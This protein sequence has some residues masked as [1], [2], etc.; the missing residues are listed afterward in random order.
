MAKT[1]YF[2][3]W[4]EA[5]PTRNATYQV[6]M[7]FLEENIL[8]RF[9]FPRKII[10]GNAQVFK[11][12]ELIN[13]CHKYNIILGH[14]T[15]YPQGNGQVESSNKGLV[16][17]IKNMLFENKKGWDSKLKYALW[18]DI[19]ITKNQLELPLFSLFMERK[20]YFLFI[21]GYLL[22]NFCKKNWKSLILFKGGFVS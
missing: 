7:K 18:A 13:L 12:A 20:I 2:T 15:H 3:K 5:I 6:V 17:T 9:A 11:S 10:A 21:L 1:N 22:W 14:W 16:R 4:I 19:I 8:A